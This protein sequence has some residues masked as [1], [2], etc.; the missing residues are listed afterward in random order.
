MGLEL[1]RTIGL[2]RQGVM[3]NDLWTGL[4]NVN[5]GGYDRMRHYE[6]GVLRVSE[7]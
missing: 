3:G 2:H 6:C 7:F 1:R 5:M 4:I